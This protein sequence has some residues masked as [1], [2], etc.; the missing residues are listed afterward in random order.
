MLGLAGLDALDLDAQPQPPH[1]EFAQAVE[2]VPRRERD[3][4]VGPNRAREPEFFERPLK[5][6][7]GKFLLRRR[8]GF[9]RQQVAAGEIGHVSG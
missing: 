7:K 9:A 8:E 3:A 4:I 2:R 5:G 1:G 6:D